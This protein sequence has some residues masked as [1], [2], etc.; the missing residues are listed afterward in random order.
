MVA[1]RK[2]YMVA[3]DGWRD[4]HPKDDP[5]VRCC[6]VCGKL[7]GWGF[8]VALR[9]AGYRMKH[10]EMGYAHPACMKRASKQAS[11]RDSSTL[12]KG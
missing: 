1:I 9:H 3:P 4:R 2:V 8:S 6:W 11:Q 5:Q 10:N 12:T 7:G